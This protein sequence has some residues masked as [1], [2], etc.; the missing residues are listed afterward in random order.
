[1]NLQLYDSLSKQLKRIE[2]D[3]DNLVKIYLCGPTVYDDIHIGNIA[4]VII[5][6]YLIRYLK[7]KQ[8]NVLYVHNI[9]DIDDKIV[10]KAQQL[11]VEES[12]IAN[13]YAEKYFELLKKLNVIWPTHTPKVSEH[14]EDIQNTIEQLMNKGYAEINEAGDVVFKLDLIPT[15]GELSKQ[16]LNELTNISDFCLWKKIQFGKT[17]DSKWGK[18][19]PGWHTECFT[20]IDKL[21]CQKVHIHGGGIDLKFP[22]HENE[23]AHCRALYNTP[24]ADIWIHIGHLS[25]PDGKISKSQNKKFLL[26]DVVD[27]YS[28][29]LL[30]L[31]F[32]KNSYST[33]SL[34]SYEILDDLNEELNSFLVAINKAISAIYIADNK[35]DLDSSTEINSEF[36]S[37]LENNLNLP[38][39]LTWLQQLKKTLLTSI[40]NKQI[41]EIKTHLSELKTHLEWLGFQIPNEHTPENLE[42]LTTWKTHIEKQEWK[43]ADEIRDK[44][45]KL[46]LI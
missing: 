46:K 10:N 8:L 45:I 3:K 32:L 5:F 16:N 18:G 17:W 22:H 41:S 13:I 35:Y 7:E 26:K 29:N 28:P 11:G 30:R 1:M 44:L 2:L 14:I 33:P 20:F 9:T 43:S 19:R 36:L 4:P 21:C 37:F 12:E 31:F 24:L 25:T 38:S 39:V 15:Y 27:S 34:V 23:N 6:D 40:K 42:L